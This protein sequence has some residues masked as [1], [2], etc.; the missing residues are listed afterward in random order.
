[1]LDTL[2]LGGG[3]PGGISTAPLSGLWQPI[4][5]DLMIVTLACVIGQFGLAFVMKAAYPKH[6]DPF[7]VADTVFSCFYFPP[8]VYL[9][10]AATLEL[11][12]DLEH[13]WHGR[14][15]LSYW[16]H[17]LYVARCIG[18]MPYLQLKV[19]KKSHFRMTAI[20]HV[21]SA[22]AY[23]TILF[24]GRIQ[25]FGCLGG[26]C[27]ITNVFLTVL[28]MFKVNEFGLM[29]R[30]P[31]VYAVNGLLLWLTFIFFRLMLFPYWLYTYGSDVANDPAN[32][33]G[34]MYTFEFLFY[35]FV[36]L[37]LLVMSI[38]W[39]RPITAGIV[40][41]LLKKQNDG[42]KVQAHD[43]GDCGTCAGK[44]GLGRKEE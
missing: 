29:Q 8:V 37:A 20:H 32:T 5:V 27:E 7:G 33:R 35:P 3:D 22:G 31:S 10:F 28:Y 13:R 39:F 23:L 4:A 9:A 12:A 11:G 2:Q 21:I 18:H 25:Y 1:M 24:L 41:V 30:F 15:S 43:S 38:D 34:K 16:Y 14:S 6:K 26:I 36:N 42:F 44:P 19:M 17:I 40:K